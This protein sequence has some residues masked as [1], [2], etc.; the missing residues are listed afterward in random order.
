MDGDMLGCGLRWGEPLASPAGRG[1]ADPPPLP[2]LAPRFSH[3]PRKTHVP[4]SPLQPGRRGGLLAGWGLPHCLCSLQTL[5]SPLTFLCGSSRACQKNALDGARERAGRACV[6]VCALVCA[7]VAT[8]FIKAKL[9]PSCRGAAAFNFL[10]RLLREAGVAF[11]RSCPG[12][13]GLSIPTTAAGPAW[14]LCPPSL[15]AAR[16]S[17]WMGGRALAGC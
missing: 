11:A 10:A 15:P 1:E 7:C 8:D 6:C 9:S 14:G 4:E 3:S 17:R 13:E 2:P 12:S 16:G 5:P